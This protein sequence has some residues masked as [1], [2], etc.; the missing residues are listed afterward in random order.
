MFMEQLKKL[1]ALG[2]DEV[3]KSLSERDRPNARDAI[4]CARALRASSQR[5]A[6]GLAA[7]LSKKVSPSS[8]QVGGT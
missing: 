1:F 3:A 7:K 4:E 8:R 2:L 6:K 5:Q